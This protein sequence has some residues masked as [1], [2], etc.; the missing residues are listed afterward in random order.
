MPRLRSGKAGAKKRYAGL[1]KK[2]DKE[3]IQFVGLEVMRSDWTE[4][5]KNFQQKLFDKIFH[6]KDPTKFINK[7]VKDIQDGKLD[8]KLI[9]IK[10][11]R[12]RPEDYIK[13]TP[14]HVKAARKLK[15]IKSSKIEYFITAEGPEPKQNLKHRLDYKHYIDKQIK[16]IA[17]AVLDF[18]GVSFKEVIEGK[19]QKKLFDF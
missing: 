3:E 18:Y 1:I 19:K 16:P 5:A 8:D 17:N 13:T 4:A 10:S 9:Y 11:L 15:E 2:G 12:K 6:K 7:Y 14:P